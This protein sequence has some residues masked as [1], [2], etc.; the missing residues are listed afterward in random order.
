[1]VARFHRFTSVVVKLAEWLTALLFATLIAVTGTQ[2]FNRL[3]FNDSIVWAEEVAKILLFYIVFTAGSIAVHRKAFS[4]IDFWGWF[5]GWGRRALDLL[6]VGLVAG[7][8]IVAIWYGLEMVRLTTT[9]ITPA[10]EIPQATIYAAVPF[11]MSLMLIVTI[12]QLLTT[13]S[14]GKV[15]TK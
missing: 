7:F 10:L 9:Q 13:L 6:I 8:Q 2:V 14:G 12:N 1:M 3:V 11:G 5:G 4:A 15:H